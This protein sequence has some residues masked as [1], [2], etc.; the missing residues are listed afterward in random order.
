MRQG[1]QI[2]AKNESI[3]DFDA[4]SSIDNTCSGIF[5]DN[6]GYTW[7]TYSRGCCARDAFMHCHCCFCCLL[8]VIC[9]R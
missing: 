2:K 8:S 3:W 6:V 9:I 1:I 4:V 7:C 5:V